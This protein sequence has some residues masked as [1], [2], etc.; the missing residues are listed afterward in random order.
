MNG[1]FD[2]EITVKWNNF[3]YEITV[4][5]TILLQAAHFQEQE[6]NN[7]NSIEV[8]E[9]KCSTECMATSKLTHIH[10]WQGGQISIGMYGNNGKVSSKKVN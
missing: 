3:Q 6:C 1:K 5:V 7:L 9:S 2:T 8:V 10:I 4:Y